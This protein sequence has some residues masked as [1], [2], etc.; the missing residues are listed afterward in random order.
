M[1]FLI[2]QYD[3]VTSTNDL[4]KEKARA[5][6][7]AG[8]V[9]VAARQTAGRGRMGRSFLSE[10]GG[11]YMSVLLRPEGAA[12]DALQ[13][14]A[15]AAVAVALAVE[16]HT[17]KPAAIKWVN[18]IYQGGKKVCGILAEGQA[19]AGGMDFVVLGIGVNLK[20]PDGGFPKE[21]RD[22]A[23]ALATEVDKEAFLCDILANL[24]K[25]PVYAEYAKRDML[26]GKTVTVYRGGEAVCHAVA[27]GIT[28]DFGLRIC[29]ERGEEVL[30]TGEVTVRIQEKRL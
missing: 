6:A 22:I 23:G 14:T 5:G 1:N 26:F 16:K 8:T 28:A 20:E 9:I 24:A 12:V 29:T 25:E 21:L 11:L 30:R 7:P 15:H 10:D 4:L 17:G 3:T 13:I 19:S 2:E 18:D 27:N